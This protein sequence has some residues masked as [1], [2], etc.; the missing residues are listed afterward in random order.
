M[1][2]EPEKIEQV[3]GLLA[4][5]NLADALESEQFRRFLDQVPIAIVVAEMKAR[6]R[7]VYANPEFEK[8]SGRTATEVESK[9]WSVLRGQSVDGTE[10]ALNA[11]VAEASD[12]VGTFRIELPGH[13]PAIVDVY[14]NVIVD[15][16]GT[17]AFRLAALVDVR[18][19]A[20]TEREE[21]ESRI[22][23]KDTLL[24]EIQHR[25]K[26]NLQM[27][28]ALIRLETRNVPRGMATAPFDRL[29]DASNLY[30]SSIRH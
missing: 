26:N 15:D 13:E 7:I 1:T 6:E 30:N 19:H 5:P 3:E 21:L 24:Y 18:G 29:Q 20:P 22:R 25:V 8:L 2:E 12:C 14:S 9:P 23:E 4:T 16:D 17:P 10:R 11:A 27:I 28:T